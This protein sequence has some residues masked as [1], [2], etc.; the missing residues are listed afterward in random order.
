MTVKS[1][2]DDDE[3]DICYLCG[4]GGPLD[5]HHIFGGP[6]RKASTRRG[7]VVHIC[8]Q[9]HSELHDKGGEKMLRLHQKGQM[10]YEEKFG[11]REQFREEFI[12]SYL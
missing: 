1:V 7:L 9:C 2:L 8:R 3:L 5:V 12:R 10:V 6:C 11:S 4:R